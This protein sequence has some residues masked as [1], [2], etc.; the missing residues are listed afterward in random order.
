MA[1]TYTTN[2]SLT[3]SEVG[4]NND[5]WGTDLNSALD[6]ADSQLVRKLDKTDITSQTSNGISFSGST[7]T[8]ATAGLF[9]NYQVGDVISI[10]GSTSNNGNHTISSKTDAQTLVVSVSVTTEAAGATVTYHL[11]P[12]FAEINVDGGTIDG[13]TVATS[14]ITTSN[15]T[16]GSGKTL[17]VS[18]GTMTFAAGQIAT[19]SIADSAITS[20]KIADAT[21][22]TG[23]IADNAI[24]AAKIAT[25]AVGS[26]EIA[27]D[28]V[29]ASEIAASSVGTSEIADD[30][31]TAA[32]IAA[33]AVTGAK[34]A[35]DSIDSEHIAA[36]SIDA[37]HYAAGSVDTTAIAADAVNG[38]KIADDSIDSEHIAADSIDTEHYAAGSITN[39]AIGDD[40]VTYAKLQDIG[41]ANR[42]LGNAST[43][44]VEEVQIATGM[45]ADAA[46]TT[47][48]LAENLSLHLSDGT[49]TVNV[50]GGPFNSDCYT[51]FSGLCFFT[52]TSGTQ[53][54]FT[55]DVDFAGSAKNF[56][57]KN[58]SHINMSGG[59][60]ITCSGGVNIT[61][62][63]PSPNAGVSLNGG[64]SVQADTYTITADGGT[65]KPVF[66]SS[67]T[68]FS[69][70]LGASANRFQDVYA[71][72][73]TIQTLDKKEKTDISDSD[74]GL[75][76]VNR[77]TPKSF[78]RLKGGEPET[79]T[80]YG[81][82][83]QD[84][85]TVLVD[86]SKTN[87][88][89]AALIKSPITDEDGKD[90]GE[91]RY[92]LR[93]DEFLGPIISAIKELSTKI[94]NL[95]TRV[96]ALEG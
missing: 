43:G 46:V 12:K 9:K 55:S 89:F 49:S 73:A 37:E 82:V 51:K 32:K 14:T 56:Y 33:D 87:V 54:T 76:F 95:T 39:A 45:I 20:V 72:N 27:A 10:A 60:D 79:R 66:D 63:L 15:I 18:A 22:A 36:D 1:N 41:T 44:T 69:V 53:V 75:D 19:A 68:N 11:V 24:T 30:A 86:I 34:I 74:L 61:G 88:D 57:V 38:A 67:T 90:T 8:S 5:N 96:V 35:D 59:G 93:Y 65:I 94:D 16:V 42:V 58:G 70:D 29:G 21:I 84:V 85:E 6:T 71:I 91:H 26:A 7:I 23:D 3:K 17:D 83:A 78:K 48:K 40:Q 31:V 80:H 25:N 62:T 28:A 4:A 13:S 64:A 52:A 77:L 81:L 2:Y 50:T 92:G 47:A